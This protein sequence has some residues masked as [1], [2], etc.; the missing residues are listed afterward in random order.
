MRGDHVTQGP[1]G[2]SFV[3][4]VSWLAAFPLL[5][6]GCDG[7]TSPGDA[8]VSSA[9][10][11]RHP[12]MLEPAGSKASPAEESEEPSLEDE[13]L[14]A[15]HPPVKGGSNPASGSAVSPPISG[16]RP[17]GT[18]Q[19]GAGLQAALSGFGL[20]VTV[21]SGWVETGA[22][23]QFRLATLR[24][25]KVEGDPEDGEMSIAN[26]MG[27][28]EENLKRWRGQFNP[29]D[30]ESVVSKKDVSGIQV[31]LVEMEGTFKGAS[32]PMVGG[33]G[34]PKPGTKLLGAIVRPPQG[35]QLIFFK[36]WGP[37][38]TMEKWKPA[39]EEFVSSLKPA[40]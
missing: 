32:G 25:P 40:K 15:G 33:G 29:E 21:P 24:L 18:S 13:G 35:N 22:A 23:S 9:P 39:F 4:M 5:F 16:S 28:E 30:P 11:P 10:R 38:A 7:D 12:A 26:A 3:G 27:G 17:A 36:A 37:R 14:P 31:T 19:R 34:P 8:G 1:F 20:A 6:L 2:G